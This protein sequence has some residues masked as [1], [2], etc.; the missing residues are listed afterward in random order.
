MAGT[1]VRGDAYVF[2]PVPKRFWHSGE[3]N[4]SWASAEE[5]QSI[6]RA[7]P[8]GVVTRLYNPAED[9]EA[10][11]LVHRREDGREA[12]GL[13]DLLERA[14]RRWAVDRAPG[15][16][17]AICTHGTRDPCCAKWGFAAYKA[18]LSLYEQGL[19]PFRPLQCSHLGG[20]RFAATGIFF[21]SGSMYAHL[22]SIDLAALIQAEAGGHIIADTY[23]GRVFDAPLLQVVRSGL[24]RAGL[25]WDSAGPLSV[26]ARSDDG[27][28][29]SVAAGD[30]RFQLTLGEVEVRFYGDCGHLKRGRVSTGRRL[31]VSG[32]VQ[33]N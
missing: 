18:A 21:P 19:S 23:R 12:E 2:L 31:V 20:D 33:V 22:D 13:A 14:G 28:A 26:I 5:I 8:L 27:L 10:A 32:A 24:A 25:C 9:G 16:Q 29:V 6:R 1:G 11:V 7:R 17:L 3:L 15:L 30:R 4:D